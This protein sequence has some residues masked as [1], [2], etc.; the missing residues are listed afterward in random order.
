MI[1]DVNR[2]NE[3]FNYST[4]IETGTHTGQ[5]T[6]YLADRFQK[7][8][9]CELYD[10]YFLQYPTIFENYTNIISVKGSSVDCLP[11][12]FDEIGNDEF[13]LYLDAH[14]VEDCPIYEELEIVSEYGY[15]PIIVI[16]DFDCGFPPPDK[17]ENSHPINEGW[18]F[19]EFRINGQTHKLDYTHMK[20]YMDKIYGVDGYDFE[21]SKIA[22]TKSRGD[23]R[24]C[25]FF[26]PKK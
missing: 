3:K 22:L 8:Y 2:I 15:K 20:P 18:Q 6:T 1:I 23:L 17:D 7:V 21:T 5:S 26:Y 19:N 11:I 4:I 13:I 25:G 10:E 14:W 12:F 9:T 16:H 24:G